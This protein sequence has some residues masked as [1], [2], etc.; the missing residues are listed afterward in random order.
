[1]WLSG[2]HYQILQHGLLE[3]L[4]CRLVGRSSADRSLDDSGVGGLVALQGA[5]D[6]DAS[7]LIDG[8]SVD[9]GTGGVSVAA[10]D[11]DGAEGMDVVQIREWAGI[12]KY[13]MIEDQG[14]ASYLPDD[15][16]FLGNEFHADGAHTDFR[17]MAEG[18]KNT[19]GIG[20]VPLKKR[21]V[22]VDAFIQCGEKDLAAGAAERGCGLG[23]DFW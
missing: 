10:G 13:R 21:A 18:F 4:P 1:M 19:A 23:V 12:A 7:K 15:C 8:F 3:G 22:G 16:L 14:S 9:A 17:H 20:A 2:F 6:A 5:L 11:P